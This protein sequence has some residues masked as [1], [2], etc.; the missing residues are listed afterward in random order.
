MKMDLS[1][2]KFGLPIVIHKDCEYVSNLQN[3]LDE[4]QK[5]ISN[6]SE[7]P[8]K[9]KYSIKDNC[10][11]LISAV[12][13]YYNADIIGAQNEIEGILRKYIGEELPFVI[14]PLGKNYAFKASAPL[15]LRPNIYKDDPELKKDYEEMMKADICLYKARVSSIPLKKEEMLHIP[16][17]ERDIIPSNRFSIAG[18]PC[19]YLSTTSLGVWLELDKPEADKFQIARYSIPEDLKIL[20]LCI[21]VGFLNGAGAFCNEEEKEQWLSYMEIFPLVIATSYT[22]KNGKER[23]FK[24]EYIISQLVMQVAQALGI[25]GVAYLSK[26][27]SGMHAYPQLVNLA[28]LMPEKDNADRYWE[29][30]KNIKL[31]EPVFLSQCFHD[32]QFDNIKQSGQ[33]KTYINQFFDNCHSGLVEYNGDR[34]KYLDTPFPWVDEYLY[35]KPMFTAEKEIIINVDYV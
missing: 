27:M 16:F 13:K 28:L 3:I 18:V 15:S 35:Q 33:R 19:M 30:T 34:C 8:D 29:G 23:K 9:R 4:Y 22:L 1:I 2:K 17:D 10:E 20:N 31:T 25:D 5:D 11:K 26:K 7:I 6:S 14:A 12:K 32:T 24:S 21:D